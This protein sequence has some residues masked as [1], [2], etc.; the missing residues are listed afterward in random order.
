MK[1]IFISGVKFGYDI[2][3]HIL[4]HNWKIE[5][6]FSYHESKNKISKDTDIYLVNSYGKTKLFYKVCYSLSVSR[7]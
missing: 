4:N 3:N 1:I 2:L 5:A 6:V 7:H